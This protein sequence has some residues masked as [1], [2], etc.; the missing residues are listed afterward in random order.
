MGVQL[1]SGI[2][3]RLWDRL[4]EAKTVFVVPSFEMDDFNVQEVPH[5]KR[6]LIKMV[7]EERIRQVHRDKWFPAHGPTDYER[8]YTTNQVYKVEY[9]RDYE[10]YYIVRQDIPKYAIPST[11]FLS[12]AHLQLCMIK[13]GRTIRGLWV[14]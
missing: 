1:N 14:R 5:N 4:H 12:Q 8:W 13:V 2:I 7:N 11:S 3:R 6:Q 9:K 10:P